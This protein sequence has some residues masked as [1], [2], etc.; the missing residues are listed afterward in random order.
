MDREK[1][2]PLRELSPSTLNRDHSHVLKSPQI[3]KIP[4]PRYDVGIS[5]QESRF[6]LTTQLGACRLIIFEQRLE[7]KRL[8]KQLAFA[9]MKESVRNTKSRPISKVG[10]SSVDED[11]KANFT[12]PKKRKLIDEETDNPNVQSSIPIAQPP[13]FPSPELKS[14]PN[15]ITTQTKLPE[16]S[17]PNTGHHRSSPPSIHF[18]GLD[19]LLDGIN[20]NEQDINTHEKLKETYQRCYNE[21]RT[22]PL[23]TSPSSGKK[24]RHTF[25]SNITREYGPVSLSD[26]PAYR[27]KFNSWKTKYA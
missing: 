14:H 16:N 8:K 23:F 21:Q 17:N 2:T 18:Q 6:T 13:I 26:L 11:P 4:K 22:I 15:N 5:S 27:E 7:I 19:R 12:T 20:E 3:K 9:H 10:K 25:L 1:R 24:K